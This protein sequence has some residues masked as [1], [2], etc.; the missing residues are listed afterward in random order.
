MT[1][2]LIKQVQH[3]T[4]GDDTAFNLRRGSV[5]KTKDALQNGG[6]YCD[7][8]YINAEDLNEVFEI[9][10]IHHEYVDRIGRFYSISVGDVIVNTDT[11]EGYLVMP[12]GF[13]ELGEV[14]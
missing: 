6:I 4:I 3:N 8:A 1:K 14:A 11:K 10:N 5:E 12:I 2:Y 13:S 9:G 7:S